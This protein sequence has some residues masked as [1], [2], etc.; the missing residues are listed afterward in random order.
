MNGQELQTVSG[1]QDTQ[2]L[3]TDAEVGFVERSLTEHYGFALRGHSVLYNLTRA[4]ADEWYKQL[5]EISSPEQIEAAMQELPHKV[6]WIDLH[7]IAIKDWS[8]AMQRWESIRATAREE[9]AEGFRAAEVMS[10]LGSDTPFQQARFLA[11]RE[12]LARDFK[13]A[14]GIERLLLDNMAQIYTV[15]EYWISRLLYRS[16]RDMMEEEDKKVIN[17]WHSPRLSEAEAQEQAAAMADRFQRMY[18]RAQRALRDMRRYA[19]IIVQAAGQV[20][21]AASGGQ[22]INVA[23]CP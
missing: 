14:N 16:H 11:L 9:L 15:H 5:E 22:Q 23:E 8:Q 7:G 2:P 19:P 18:L 21:V 20:N 6:R 3:V 13:P 17:Y 1:G 4:E 12:E 10:V